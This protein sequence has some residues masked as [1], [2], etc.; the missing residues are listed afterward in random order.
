MCYA[1]EQL[2]R[3]DI[4]SSLEVVSG[5][6]FSQGFEYEKASLSAFLTFQDGDGGLEEGFNFSIKMGQWSV[7]KAECNTDQLKFIVIE[8]E[9][10][11]KSI[12]V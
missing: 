8:G 4:S 5:G 6:K 12:A 2:Y 11:L 1:G 7:S 10:I 9:H 3:S